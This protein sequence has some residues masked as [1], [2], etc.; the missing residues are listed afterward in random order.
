MKIVEAL[1]GRIFPAALCVAALIS[2]L[3]LLQFIPAYSTEQPV[4]VRPLIFQRTLAARDA[5]EVKLDPTAYQSLKTGSPSRSMQFPISGQKNVVLQLERFDIVTAHARF[6]VGNAAGV[7][8]MEPPDVVLFRGRVADEPESYAYLAFTGQGSG[9]GYVKTGGDIYFM[10]QLPSEIGRPDGQGITIHKADGF[11]ELPDFEEFCKVIMPEGGLEL[12][13]Y[14]IH[15]TDTIAGPR[16]AE[17]AMEADQTFC[18][19][20]PDTTATENYIIQLIG[21]ISDIYLRDMD[22]K[23]MVSFLRLWPNGGEPFATDDLYSFRDHWLNNEDMTGLNV[24]HLLTARRDLWYGG[25]AYMGGTCAGYAFATSGFLNGHFPLP[26]GIPNIGNWDIQVVAHEMGHNFFGFHTHDDWFDPHID[27]CGNG[28]YSRG[29]IM[30]YCHTT[31]GYMSNTDM[32][33][34]RRVQ[35]WM[36]GDIVDGGCFWF[37]CNNNGDDDARDIAFGISDDVNANGIPDECEDCNENGILDDIDIG[38]GMPDVNQNGIPDVCEADCNGNSIPDEWETREHMALDDNGN[39]VPD[40]CDTDCDA[41][42]IPDFAEVASGAKE[43]VDNNGI[44]DVCQDCNDN[45][46]SDWLDLGREFNLF[47]ADA[48]GYIREYHTTN[49]IPIRNIGQGVLTAPFDCTFGPDRQLYVTCGA[50]VVRIDVDA[51]TI[52]TFA[53]M[54]SGGMNTPTFLTFGPDDNL[55]VSNLSTHEVLKFDGSTGGFIGIFIT[56]GLGGLIAPY[57]LEFGP[58]GNLFVAGGNNAIYEYSGSD[59][60]FVGTFVPTGYGGISGPRGIAF[61]QDGTLLVANQSGG[62][63]LAYD[64]AGIF[65]GVFNDTTYADIYPMGIRIGRSGNVFIAHIATLP[66][67]YE[68]EYPSGRYFRRYV[69]DDPGIPSANGF[70]FRPGAPSDADGDYLLDECEECVDSDADG[71]GDPGYPDN[72]CLTDN[73]PGTA[74]ADQ[75]DSDADGI[76]DVCDICP[77]D[78]YNDVDGDGLCGDEDNCPTVA[79]IG[80]ADTDSDGIGNACDNCPADSNIHQLDEDNDLVGDE[81]DNCPQIN[82]PGQDDTDNDGFGDLCDNC[83]SVYN[84]D[85][86]DTNSNDIGD[87]CEYICGDADGSEAINLLDVTYLINYLYKGGPAPDPI[88]AGD[89]DGSS[90]INILDVTY[91]IRYLYKGGPEPVCP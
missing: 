46:I 35:E 56:S 18:D 48:S 21:A 25:L 9:N 7:S 19:I 38:G 54:G 82:N 69:R 76:G 62:R 26:V 66:Q 63:I 78:P 28:T 2:A 24:F 90:A 75:L 49:G 89:A 45:D 57:G 72:T 33:F 29:T 27:D 73:C 65:M 59:G 30:S 51:G 79:N 12:K 64:N 31:T 81:C 83:P 68:Y 41:N 55:Y 70:A 42:G 15:Y 52:S 3:L 47:V 88:E 17:L 4:A 84:P 61:A 40:E 67:I 71:Y 50:G 87:A 1:I 14:S 34:H 37:D 43:D 10:S 44:P 36:E 6:L 80:Q 39:C 85:Q 23:L 58:G 20:F 13:E 60:S 5:L 8:E 86:L 32:R 11:G 22:I 53:P 16:V 77:N 91:L 74:N